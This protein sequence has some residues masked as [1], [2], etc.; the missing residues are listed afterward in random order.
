LLFREF[1]SE[2]Q[3]DIHCLLRPWKGEMS[4]ALMSL[5]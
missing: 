2:A 3:Q 5:S 4:I 1:N